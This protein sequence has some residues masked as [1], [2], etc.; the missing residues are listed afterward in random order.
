MRF[1]RL[2]LVVLFCVSVV[3]SAVG[4]A[5]QSRDNVVP[6]DPTD[7]RILQG[8]KQV[9]E[10]DN[11]MV[12]TQTL[13]ATEVA[14]GVLRDGGNAFDAD[15]AAAFHQQVTEPHMISPWGMAAGIVY[16]S[17]SDEFAYFD[18]V[19]ERPLASRSENGDPTIVAIGG[20]VK[21]LGELWKRYGTKPW[22]YYMQPAIRAAEEGV[23]VTAY[24]YGVIYAAWENTN[25]RWPQGVRD[26][27]DNEEARRFYMPDGF[28]VTVGERWKMPA[29][30][31]HFRRL[32]AA[33]PDYMYTGE[34]GRKFV[35]ESNRLG[36]AVTMEDMT[37]Y[38]I[39]W[40]EPIRSSFRGYEIIT[41]PSPSDGGLIVA[42][43]LNILENFDLK[44]MGHFSEPA[45]AM[46]LI[47]RTSG[48]VHSEVQRIRDPLNY[49]TPTDLLL[50]K[51]YG[52]MG[53]EFIRMTG[54]APAGGLVD[55][56]SSEG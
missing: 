40:S 5:E 41:E 8:R 56:S 42:Y 54:L 23:L 2:T 22:E 55:F 31:D 20:T 14:L 19:S 4:F 29:L 36:G 50:S 10:G 27:I 35:E 48:R 43:N 3:S 46:D 12:S 52:R 33:G 49:Y 18:G 37:E 17:E 47:F 30:A 13:A 7:P 24:M 9:A 38:E 15:I 25:A 34:W 32:A 26:L 39:R 44:E 45:E 51:E 53:A 1:I 16:V 28:L 21:A 6:V 11:V